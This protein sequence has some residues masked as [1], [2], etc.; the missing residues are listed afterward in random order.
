MIKAGV[1]FIWNGTHASIPAGWSRVTDMDGKYAKGTADATNPNTTG[2]ATTHT[3]TSPTHTHTAAAHTH[4]V[5]IGTGSGGGGNADTGSSGMVRAHTHN[6]ITSGAVAGFTCDSPAATYGA[7]S[8]DP[9]YYEVI[10]VTPTSDITDGA[11]PTG[12]VCLADASAPAGF[13]VCDGNNS[14]PNLVDK[15]LKG[16]GAG[17]NAGGTGGS[18]T[19]IHALSHTHSTSHSHAASSTGGGSG[20]TSGTKASGSNTGYG[21]HT[22]SVTMGVQD[23][24]VPDETVSLTTTE[25]VEPAYTKL[26]AIKNDSSAVIVLGVIGMWL[27]TLANIPT[28]WTLC[29]GSGG[30]VDMRG[31]HLKITATP[32]SS[33][34]TGGS[35]THTHGSQNHG[36][37]TAHSGHTASVSHPNNRGLS[38]SGRTGFTPATTHDCTV[39]SINLVLDN[40]ATTADS[41]S[42]EPA[43]RTVAFI[44]LTSLN[45]DYLLELGESLEFSNTIHKVATL[46]RSFIDDILIDDIKSLKPIKKLYESLEYAEDYFRK[47]TKVFLD[48]VAV[49]E[50]IQQSLII[51]F[52]EFIEITEI[53]INKFITSFFES[54]EVAENLI[55]IPIKIL[56]EAIEFSEHLFR[57]IIKTFTE[58]IIITETVDA[59]K[60]IFQV[61]TESIKIAETR[62]NT[63]IK[64]LFED[65]VYTE[66]RY[67]KI[68]ISF[69]ENVLITEVLSQ[70][71]VIIKSFYESI[72]VSELMIKKTV[73]IF[74]ESIENSEILY[75]VGTFIRTFTEAIIITETLLTKA[76]KIFVRAYTESIAVGEAMIKTIIK[77]FY[78][79]IKVREHYYRLLA[80]TRDFTESIVFTETLSKVKTLYKF[81]TEAIEIFEIFNV[82]LQNFS[83]KLVGKMASM[84]ITGSIKSIV[85]NSKIKGL[86]MVGGTKDIYLKGKIKSQ[87][88]IGKIKHL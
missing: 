78:E 41:S 6:N 68:V 25:T 19:N 65:I 23:L 64:S 77:S 13:Y 40:A 85:I 49:A 53:R 22:H 66:K 87:D 81:L 1:I 80:F 56:S 28:G 62:L 27:G 32:A 30:T 75:K 84:D 18:T 31:R 74:A 52:K 10:F 26:L 8:N 67:S 71:E 20:T 17:G 51:K 69:I 37:T 61:F 29:N 33:G 50:K 11:L 7:V 58:S 55:K 14:T 12:M 16:A 60:I 35:N 24:T 57:K 47:I 39:N 2:E 76:F 42:N 45:Q 21:T 70:L 15:Y 34:A 59:F 73:K 82:S 48:E 4:T 9:P 3:H 46:K 54:I 36:H 86:K 79:S 5:T 43:F 63:A 88:I 44:K 83:K 72:K 38:G